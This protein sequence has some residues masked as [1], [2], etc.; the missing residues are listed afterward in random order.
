MLQ[1]RTYPTLRE[2]DPK[3]WDNIV[4]SANTRSTY[5]YLRALEDSGCLGE[6]YIFTVHEG[7]NRQVMASALAIRYRED[8]TA[9]APSFIK[10]FVKFVRRFFPH[11][12]F[13]HFIEVGNPFDYHCMLQYKPPIN[14][15]AIRLLLNSL[16]NLRKKQNHLHS[17]LITAPQCSATLLNLR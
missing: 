4:H 2:V 6:H 8:L 11:F 15:K 14:K 12:L 13:C 3:E 16:V 7:K 17:F 9:Y 5:T 10:I 1:V